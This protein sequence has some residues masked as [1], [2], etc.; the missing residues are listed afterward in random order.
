MR[1]GGKGSAQRPIA[2]RKTFEE[3][4]DAIFGRG[5]SRSGAVGSNNDG[6]IGVGDRPRKEG[7]AQHGDER[8]ATHK[9]AK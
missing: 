1:D 3:N 2:N 6:G 7:G 9:P 8:N 4:W 5:F